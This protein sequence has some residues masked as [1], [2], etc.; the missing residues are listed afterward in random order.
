M[1]TA[2]KLPLSQRINFR[3]I[4]FLAIP[5]LLFG[6]FLYVYLDQTLTG[7]IA[8]RGD[9][10]EVKELKAMG[11]FIFDDL[12]GT[13]DDIPQQYRALN[14][15]RVLLTGQ[16]YPEGGAGPEVKRFQLVYSIAMCCF[17]GPPRVQERVYVL[18][19]DNLHV[20]N[21]YDERIRV[22]GK[23]DVG[24][25]RDPETGKVVAVY[26]MVADKVEPV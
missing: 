15:K 25:K 13:D 1:D 10:V 8:D 12:I 7:G 5:V 11:N 18:V 26:R 6:W 22:Y 9:Y 14:G 4:A 20:A 24:C 23:L 17:N 16:L 21:V 2:V 19:P 3:L